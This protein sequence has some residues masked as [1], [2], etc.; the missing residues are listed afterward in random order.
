MNEHFNLH[1]ILFGNPRV[2]NPNHATSLSNKNQGQG[3]NALGGFND[4]GEWPQWNWLVDAQ[5]YNGLLG[6]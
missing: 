4:K 1:A 3:G 6:V 5:R 2:H